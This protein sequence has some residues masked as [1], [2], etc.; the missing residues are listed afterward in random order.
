MPLFSCNCILNNLY[1]KL[2]GNVTPPFAGLVTFGEVA[3]HL[4]N[5]TLV[6]AE[7]IDK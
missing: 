4:L 6:Y 3:Y 2:E 5:Q 1:G 7:I